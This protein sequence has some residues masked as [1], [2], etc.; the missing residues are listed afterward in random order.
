MELAT[1]MVKSG[2]AIR[3]NT[4]TNN[5]SVCQSISLSTQRSH[6]VS[7]FRTCRPL[8]Q[9]SIRTVNCF[10]SQENP[11]DPWIPVT[12]EEKPNY[13]GVLLTK[14]SIR[15]C[16]ERKLLQREVRYSCHCTSRHLIRA[17]VAEF[18]GFSCCKGWWSLPP[19]VF[20]P[21]EDYDCAGPVPTHGGH[22]HRKKYDYGEID[23]TVHFQLW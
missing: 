7:G 9:Q 4:F 12:C 11:A 16:C 14:R 5:L 22:Q 19:R 20:L 10:K 3:V 15:W 6:K 13:S 2:P 8:P 17:D 23:Q 18:N 1:E 21:Q